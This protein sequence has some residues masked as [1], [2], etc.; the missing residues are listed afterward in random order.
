MG[1]GIAKAIRDTFPAAFE[2]DRETRKGDRSK[3]GTISSARIEVGERELTVV[4]AYTQFHWRGRKP[5]VDYEAIRT[6]FSV[7]RARFDG[8]RIGYPRIGAGLA[9]GDWR[10]IASILDEQL[11]GQRHTLVE[12]VG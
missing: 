9:G 3:S 12:Y 1:A 4:N 7:I 2:A 5:L 8:M 10:R 6:A 11:E